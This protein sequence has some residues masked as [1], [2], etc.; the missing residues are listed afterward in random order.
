[1]DI[2]FFIITL[3]SFIIA[4]RHACEA[5]EIFREE[6]RIGE[7]H[8]FS[9]L[10]GSLVSMTQLYFDACDE[11]TVYPVFGGGSTGLTDDGGAAGYRAEEVQAA[12]GVILTLNS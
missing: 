8:L 10:N 5:A 1:M 11:G 9:Y 4:G 2:C 6:R 7:V 3:Y 12:P